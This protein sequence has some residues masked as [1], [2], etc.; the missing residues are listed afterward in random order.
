[1]PQKKKPVQTKAAKSKQLQYH[2]Y[3]M[4]IFSK[5]K[6]KHITFAL[7]SSEQEAN[8]V[9]VGSHFTQLTSP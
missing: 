7:I 5:R 9:P 4:Q 2:P 1:M 8:R 3:K 6:C